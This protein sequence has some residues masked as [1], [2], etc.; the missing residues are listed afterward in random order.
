MQ[1]AN[2]A[3]WD[4]A[5]RHLYRDAFAYVATGPRRHEDWTLDVLAL[6]ARDISDPRGWARVD[7]AERDPQRVRNPMYPFAVHPPEYIAPRLK[8][9]DRASAENLLLALTEAGCTLSNLQYF[10]ESPD[11]LR[12]MARTILARYGD[13][14]TYH[15]NVSKQGSAPGTLDFTLKS[16]GYSPLGVYMEDCGLVIVTDT[17]VGLFWS[18]SD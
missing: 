18:I 15:T 6:M 8:E 13:E 10:D 1:S 12:A 14:A 4:A 16:F 2:Q 5:V 9:I 7:D 17:E 11:E 3:S